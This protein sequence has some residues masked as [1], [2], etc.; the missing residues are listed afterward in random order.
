M[1]ISPA[2]LACD[3]M[4]GGLARWLRAAGHDASWIYGIEDRALVDFA[5]REGRIVLS[6]DEP[7]CRALLAAGLPR[8]ASREATR[9][10]IGGGPFPEALF[11]PRGLPKIEG[12]R[13]VLRS[14]SLS[15]LEPRCMPC[16]GSLREV[17][18]ESVL[19]EAPPRTLERVRRFDRC[20]ECG[21]LFWK[22][23]HWERISA[24]LSKCSA[25]K[26]P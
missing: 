26:I 5:R 10:P 13:H 16:G 1:R 19:D 4:L 22:G 20:T 14:L 2:R 23:T 6:S 7:L 3:A 9:P 15:L 11:V 17:S 8:T 24:G 12:L 18:A 21:K 25:P